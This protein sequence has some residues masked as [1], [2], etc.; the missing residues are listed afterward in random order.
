LSTITKKELALLAS[1][2]T[3]PKKNLAAQLVDSLF[4]AMRHSLIQGHRRVSALQRP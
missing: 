3:G 1:E 4:N 2:R